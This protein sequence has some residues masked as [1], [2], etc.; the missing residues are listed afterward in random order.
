LRKLMTPE[1]RNAGDQPLRAHLIYLA[2]APQD[3]A[4]LL[5]RLRGAGYGQPVM[6][7]DSF[8]T[9]ELVS[10]GESTGGGVYFTTHAALGLPHSTPYMRRFSNWYTSAYGRPPENAFAGLGF[11]TVN[12]IAKA[13]VRA[14]SADPVKVRDQLLK[15]RTFN[16][17]TGALTYAGDTFVPHKAVTIIAVGR[18]AELAAQITP[19]YS[20]QP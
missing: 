15:L 13:I 4:P 14:K 5:R 8:D 3:A 10:A 6:G 2:A 1:G 11:D 17:V 16:G 7:G 9:S 20:P 19:V 18:E 12:L